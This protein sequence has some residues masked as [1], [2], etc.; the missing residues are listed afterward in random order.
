MAIDF[1]NYAGVPVQPSPVNTAMQSAMNAMTLL[2]APAQLKAQAQQRAL[3]NQILAVQAANAPII[4][5][6]NRQ[7]WLDQYDPATMARHAQAII[8]AFN[9][10]SGGSS[11]GVPSATVAPTAVPTNGVAPT[12]STG[13]GTPAVTSAPLQNSMGGAP[14]LATN[15]PN[16]AN[17]GNVAAPSLTNQTPNLNQAPSLGAGIP[18]LSQSLA[19]QLIRKQFG[20]G[21]LKLTPQQQAQLNVAQNTQIAQNKT[22]MTDAQKRLGDAQSLLEMSN[23][24][25]NMTDVLNS[26]P[27]AVGFKTAAENKINW[28]GDPQ[29]IKDYGTFNYNAGMLQS[30]I[31][32]SL[33]ARNL[34][35]GM[36]NWIQNIKPNSLRSVSYNQGML[37]SARQ[38]IEQKFNEANQA[39]QA[40]TGSPLP[41]ALPSYHPIV[42]QKPKISQIATSPQTTGASPQKMTPIEVLRA[43]NPKVGAT[44]NMQTGEWQ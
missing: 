34:G 12:A 14:T 17:A 13:L 9:S 19:Q 43:A 30:T 1:T 41:V 6:Q 36:M 32:Q 33:K 37:D 44:L 7:Q 4:A 15:M 24:V 26:N 5:A 42:T 11:T 29:S 31:A 10:V 27:N 22:N 35:I 18:N 21:D 25:N 40:E 38:S 16:A 23:Y 2:N 39:Y 3:N 20:L 28:P 8:N